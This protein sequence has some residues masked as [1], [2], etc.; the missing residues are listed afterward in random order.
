[1]LLKR[2]LCRET[3]YFSQLKRG[4]LL[5]LLENASLLDLESHQL[6]EKKRG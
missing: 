6:A 3:P 1:L 4:L 2:N 5:H